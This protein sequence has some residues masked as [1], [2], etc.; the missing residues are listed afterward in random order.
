M[1]VIDDG[2]TDYRAEWARQ[3]ALFQPM[4]EAKHR[5][6]PVGEEYLLLTEHHPVYTLGR[7]GHAANMLLSPALLRASGAELIPIERG[8]DI[9]FH[10][11]GQLVAYPIIDLERRSMGIRR[12]IW[13]LEEAVIRLCAH[14]GL[15]AGRVDG[16]TG[17]WLGIGETPLGGEPSVGSSHGGERKICAIGV[18]CSRFV[19]MHGLALNVNTD[20]T[21]F[22]A[23][24][25]CGFTDR[26]VTSLA[27]ELSRP[28]D[29]SEAKSL[30]SS[31]LL[32]LLGQ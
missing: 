18:R 27:A 31:N 21:R 29:M 22:S 24:N 2:L 11:P 30:L 6:Q 13:C 8:G 7:H 14:Y 5:R 19:T 1:K 10:G 4:V 9:T 17:V 15:R 26:G 20:L 23:I 3:L 12:Y 25:P 28:V 16:A 32:T